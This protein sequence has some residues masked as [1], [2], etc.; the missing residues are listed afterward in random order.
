MYTWAN[1]DYKANRVNNLRLQCEEQA[2]ALIVCLLVTMQRDILDFLEVLP[3]GKC[4]FLIKHSALIKHFFHSTEQSGL[5]TLASVPNTVRTSNQCLC[6]KKLRAPSREAL[7]FQMKNCRAIWPFLG[8]WVKD[9]VYIRGRCQEKA[10]TRITETVPSWL[11]ADWRLKVFSAKAFQEELLTKI[12][13]RPE[14]VLN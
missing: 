3:A 9:T 8:A 10:Q 4:M 2:Q 11:Q 14:T 7:G 6:Q 13:H 5:G 12:P 1:Q